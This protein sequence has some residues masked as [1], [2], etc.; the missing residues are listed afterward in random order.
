MESKFVYLHSQLKGIYAP[1]KAYII[2]A[3]TIPPN[4]SKM[5]ELKPMFTSAADLDV[6]AEAELPVD[7]AVE[8]LVPE[9]DG[10][11]TT[12]LLLAASYG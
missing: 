7:V 11:E 5:I 3:D 4:P 12:L 1:S 10:E 6:V 8:E 9:L 2:K